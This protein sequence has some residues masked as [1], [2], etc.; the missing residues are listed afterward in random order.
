[1]QFSIWTALETDAVRLIV[2]QRIALAGA[3]SGC[4]SVTGC[5][6]KSVETCCECL[7]M[8]S[9]RELMGINIPNMSMSGSA[10]LAK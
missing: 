7:R 2:A 10:C 6:K 1:M 3:T 5:Y 8:Q 4:F 9:L